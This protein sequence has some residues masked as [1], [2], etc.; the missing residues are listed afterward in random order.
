MKKIY[1]I[2]VLFLLSSCFGGRTQPSSFYILRPMPEEGV[3]YDGNNMFVG[4]DLIYIS[5]YLDR[6]EMITIGNNSTEITMSEFNRWA[7]PLSNSIQRNIVLN[8]TSYM[9]NALIRP[10]NAFNKEFDY[11]VLVYINRLDGEFN[12]KAYLDAFYSIVNK[13]GDVITSN[14]LYLENNLGSTY[15][16]LAVQESKLISQ[17]SKEISKKL[18]KIKK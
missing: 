8:M 16:D 9:K 13:K 11:I 6:K 5:S 17:L 12:K 7:E 2:L 10:I 14:K 3:K 4:I 18:S 15:D 1:L